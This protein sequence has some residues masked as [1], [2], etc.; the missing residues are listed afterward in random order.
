M[1]NLPI[2]PALPT[3]EVA[4]FLPSG[5]TQLVETTGNKS[6]ATGTATLPAS[7]SQYTYIEGFEVT[8]AGATATS[9]IQVAVTDGTWTLTYDM[10]IPAGVTAAVTPLII[11]YARPLK[12]SAIN[13]SITVTMPSFGAG[14]TNCCCNA[15]GY[16]L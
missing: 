1:P 9:I 11:R 5:A 8:G 16:N 15:V 4:A 13:T 2:V 10:V 14:N 12:S 6:A 7:T 3:A